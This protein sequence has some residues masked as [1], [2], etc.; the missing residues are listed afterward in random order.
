MMSCGMDQWYKES[1]YR[2]IR[3]EGSLFVSPIHVNNLSLVTREG[4]R[5]PAGGVCGACGRERRQSWCQRGGEE[6]AFF[7][8]CR[9]MY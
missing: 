9:S 5:R 1:P 8:W 2:P 6:L 3:M 4:L 7:G